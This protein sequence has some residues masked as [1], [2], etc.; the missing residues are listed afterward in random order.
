MSKLYKVREMVNQVDALARNLTDLENAADLLSLE[1]RMFR[2]LRQRTEMI[3]R[4][5]YHL[6]EGLEKSKLPCICRIADCVSGAP[7]PHH[8]RNCPRWMSEP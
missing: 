5:I 7:G 3:Y 4:E 2:G 8:E 6:L 1:G